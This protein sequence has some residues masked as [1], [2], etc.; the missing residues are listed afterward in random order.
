MN[1]HL[2]HEGIASGFYYGNDAGGPGNSANFVLTA[3]HEL[4]H[5]LGFNTLL[6]PNGMSLTPDPDIFHRN[7]R[8]QATGDLSINLPSDAD[9]AQSLADGQMT[10]TGCNVLADRDPARPGL[11]NGEIPV[12]SGSVGHWTLQSSGFRLLSP[13]HC[14]LTG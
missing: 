5:A 13:P 8:D 4:G 6:L 14:T 10:W 11:V 2:Y 12:D 3:L 7:L 9:R 1:C